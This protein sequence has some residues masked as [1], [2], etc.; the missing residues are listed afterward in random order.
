VEKMFSFQWRRAQEASGHVYP[1][2]F[3]TSRSSKNFAIFQGKKS[4][5]SLTLV[6]S[7]STIKRPLSMVTIGQNEVAERLYK[8]WP[9]RIRA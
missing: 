9:A 7:N 1:L 2:Y 8:R 3:K 6:K 5:S 4:L